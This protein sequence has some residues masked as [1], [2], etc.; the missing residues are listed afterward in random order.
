MFAEFAFKLKI[1]HFIT[2]GVEIQN[3]VESHA[4]FFFFEITNVQI[5]L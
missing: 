2:V 1:S 4:F 5:L 3:A